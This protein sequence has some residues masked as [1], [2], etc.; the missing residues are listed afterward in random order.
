[1]KFPNLLQEARR[2]LVCANLPNSAAIGRAMQKAARNGMVRTAA[3]ATPLLVVAGTAWAQNSVPGASSVAGSPAGDPVVTPLQAVILGLVQ[4]LTEFIPV[5]S[6][7]HLNIVHALMGHGRELTYDVLLSV[8]TTL[9][10]GYYFRKEWVALL[11]DPE[12]RKLRNLILLSSVPAATL[13]VLIHKFEDQPP[14]S[15]PQ[16]NATML[17]VAGFIMWLADRYSKKKRSIGEVGTADALIVGTA[18][19]VAL[20]PGVSRS[21]A[22]LT[23][24]LMLGFK[25]EDAARFSFL[26]SMPINLGAVMYELYGLTKPGHSLAGTPAASMVLGILVSA[27]SGFWAIGFLLNYLKTRDVTPFFIWRVAVAL[28]VFKL[29]FDQIL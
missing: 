1:M 11:R 19:A 28:I 7:G 22:T 6:S 8:G 18:Q 4:G 27:V 9:A 29:S 5:S 13:G 26:M 20:M 3:L 17:I 16:F 24:A 14:L 25:R 15:L 12:Q 23:A 10:L 2:L 21:G